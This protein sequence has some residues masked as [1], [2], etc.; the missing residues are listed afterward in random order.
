MLRARS[1]KR[2]ERLLF[3]TASDS[4]EPATLTL[5]ATSRGLYVHQ[6]SGIVPERARE[7]YEIPKRFEA[8]T[9]L[10]IGFAGAPTGD[11]GER[12]TSPRNRRALDE[13][14]FTGRFDRPFTP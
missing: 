1:F 7:L 11:L 5:E 9:G 14:I 10:A 13:S 2:V 12:D 4:G 3:I 8:V 6:M